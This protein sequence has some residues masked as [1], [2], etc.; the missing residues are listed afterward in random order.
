MSDIRQNLSI[1]GDTFQLYILGLLYADGCNYPPQRRVKI[2]LQEQDKYILDCI[3]KEINSN[4]PLSFIPL[5]DKN[6]N[7]QNTYRLDIVNKKLYDSISDSSTHYTQFNIIS[8][9]T[10]NI[11]KLT[12]ELDKYSKISMGIALKHFEI[13]CEHDN[14]NIEYRKFDVQ[15]KR[16][17]VYF[18]SILEKSM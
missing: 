1:Y 3:N 4:K 15:D 18:I 2:E 7:W 14:I 17:K 8:D 11:D 12:K 10:N 9:N 13:G 6:P 5:H 16:R